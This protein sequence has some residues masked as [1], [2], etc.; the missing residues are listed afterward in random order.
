MNWDAIGAVGQMIGALAVIV[1]LAY[2]SLQTRASRIQSS[3]DNLS[4]L[5][6]HSLGVRDR[7]IKSAELW[8]KGN[9]GTELSATEQFEFDELVQARTDLDFYSFLRFA[10]LGGALSNIP[11]SGLASFFHRYPVAFAR[12]SL[13]EDAHVASRRVLGTKAQEGDTWVRMVSEAVTALQR[14]QDRPVA[15]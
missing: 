3:L 10:A 11:V 1:T 5:G 4:A 12:W 2:L 6:E 7:F 15:E 9:A 8:V 13:N 14:M